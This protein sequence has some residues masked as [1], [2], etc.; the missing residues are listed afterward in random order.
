[1]T[2]AQLYAG[3]A[4][5]I[6]TLSPAVL[7]SLAPPCHARKSSCVT[8]RFHRSASSSVG[9]AH[10]RSHARTAK[11]P[12]A[13]NVPFFSRRARRGPECAALWSRPAVRGR[14]CPR[15]VQSRGRRGKQ[16]HVVWALAC[17]LGASCDPKL[18]P[19][20]RAACVSLE[21][22]RSPHVAPTRVCRGG[23]TRPVSIAPAN[24]R[25]PRTVVM[26]QTRLQ[27]LSTWASRTTSLVR[28]SI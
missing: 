21:A 24:V 11:P 3:I 7:C 17:R 6:T 2:T 16:V 10:P 20:R 14:A 22:A 4:N 19:S 18:W 1:M 5:T 8:A 9:C 23:E 28:A 27:V 13:S 15:A 25:P 26:Q 12:L